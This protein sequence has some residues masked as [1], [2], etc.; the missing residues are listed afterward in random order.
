MADLP[1]DA[2]QVIRQAP[3][4]AIFRDFIL[5]FTESRDGWKALRHRLTIN[6]LGEL[7]MRP[8]P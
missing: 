4:P 1:I 8:M 7:V 5:R 6:L 2:D 3:E